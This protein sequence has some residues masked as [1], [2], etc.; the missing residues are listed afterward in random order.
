MNEGRK[1]VLMKRTKMTSPL[2]ISQLMMVGTKLTKTGRQNAPR[3]AHKRR[4]T[5][6]K[7]NRCRKLSRNQFNQRRTRMLF[8]RLM[9]RVIRLKRLR[10]QSLWKIKTVISM[11]SGQAGNG[12][13]LRTF[14]NTSRREMLKR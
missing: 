10:I 8:Q 2:M 6:I 1:T 3:N 14:T 12:L 4:Q 11:M 9:I 7:R 13:L 5:T